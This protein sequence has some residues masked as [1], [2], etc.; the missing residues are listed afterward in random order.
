[1]CVFLK[2]TNKCILQ[3]KRETFCCSNEYMRNNIQINFRAFR[4]K[5][6]RKV[7]IIFPGTSKYLEGKLNYRIYISWFRDVLNGNWLLIYLILLLSVNAFDNVSVFVVKSIS[8]NVSL[9]DLCQEVIISTGIH[10]VNVF[11]Q[12]FNPDTSLSLWIIREV[13]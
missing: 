3:N 8:G 2:N 5:K 12:T 9:K 7:H 4:I 1:M 11:L 10:Q 13:K 6:S